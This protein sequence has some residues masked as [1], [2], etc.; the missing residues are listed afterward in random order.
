MEGVVM[1]SAIL[2]CPFGPLMGVWIADAIGRRRTLLFA[3]VLFMASSIGCALAHHIWV[4]AGWRA[5]EWA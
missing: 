4:F 2:G 5:A 1:G 3:G